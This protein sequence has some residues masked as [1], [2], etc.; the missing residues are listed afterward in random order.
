MAVDRAAPVWL[1]GYDGIGKTAL[2]SRTARDLVSAGRFERVVYSSL[3]RNGVPEAALYDLGQCL[4]GSDFKLSAD[5]LPLIEQALI[6]T[7]TLVIWDDVSQ[8]LYGGALALDQPAL[9]SWYQTASRIGAQGSS[10]LC[11]VTDGV[12]LPP[13]ARRLTGVREYRLAAMDDV[14]GTE[15]GLALDGAAGLEGTLAASW[16]QAVR[17][18]GG[19]PLALQ[20]ISAARQGT[21]LAA[22]VAALTEQAPGLASGEGRFRNRALDVALER[23]SRSIG[24]PLGEHLQDLGLFVGGFIQ[25]LGPEI[26]NLS[27]EDWVT[28]SAPLVEAGLVWDE[29]LPM[30]TIP[31]VRLHPALQRWAMQRLTA[32]RRAEM[33]VAHY[34]H[35]FGFIT[36][37]VQN[38]AT[39]KAGG[40]LLFLRDMGNVRQG[41]SSILAAGEVM[42]SVNY[43]QIYNA[44]LKELGFDQESDRATDAVSRATQTLLPQ[45]GP[46]TRTGVE[47]ALKQ[48]EALLSK[49]DVQKAGGLL[50]QLATRFEKPDG[51][52][53]QG[54]PATLDHIRALIDLS[55]VLRATEHGDIAI[56]ALNQAVDLL[57]PFDADADTRTRRAEIYNELVEVHL[58]LNQMDEAARA[59]QRAL[60]ALGDLDNPPMQSALH[61]RAAILAMR[62]NDP[63]TAHEEF[64][65][66]S[67]IMS[68]YGDLAG[69]ASVESQLAALAMRPPADIP[70]AMEHLG[71]AIDYAHRGEQWPVEAQLHS[72]MAQLAAQAGMLDQCQDHLE[73]AVALYA[74]NEAS[75]PL[76]VARASL[77]EFYLR[78]GNAD[79]ALSE[80]E[81]ALSGSE[82]TGQAVPWELFLLLERIASARGDQA[83][84]TRWRTS[85]QDAY[86]ASPVAKATLA[87]WARLLDALVRAAQGEAL[88]TEAAQSLETM[89]STPQWAGLARS[90]W[91]VLSGERDRALYADL[92]HV[93][94]LVVRTLLQKIEN[95]ATGTEEPRP[96]E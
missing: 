40:P 82:S 89:E 38:A 10:A 12:E 33:T 81:L 67:E 66:A 92:D 22:V 51:V 48:A 24:Q 79:Q 55:R 65:R 54:T 83:S 69:M 37:I 57:D 13:S 93:D 90:L 94:A 43:I 53:Y 52:D 39:L 25:N 76:V 73:R 77:A 5:A 7:P 9:L 26:M 70:A 84:L 61:A 28:P 56:R 35:Y 29:P 17:L 8:I 60:S 21:T 75:A 15:L 80:A 46:W 6:N 45:E 14:E 2:V 3:G 58:Q 50:S 91:R 49:G 64:K 42:L 88:E 63:D 78:Q 18:L 87:R 62:R 68:T 36:W 30:M 19:H 41:L 85:T 96:S 27:R 72:Q 1:T 31:M 71:K 20:C 95:A 59:C 32:K 34:S 11:V 23:L 44:L 4:I 16:E 86:A 47:L 74:A